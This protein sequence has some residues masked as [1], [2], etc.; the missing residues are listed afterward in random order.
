MYIPTGRSEPRTEDLQLLKWIRW[1]TGSDVTDEKVYWKELGCKKNI[2]L[3]QNVIFV[4]R[5]CLITVLFVD[6]CFFPEVRWIIFF[7]EGLGFVKWWA[8][9]SHGGKMKVFC[10]LERCGGHIRRLGVYIEMHA[11]AISVCWLYKATL[12][13]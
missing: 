9:V 1:C 4:V 5:I 11:F 3:C 6:W 12:K 10:S 7:Y 8:A 2:F 13:T